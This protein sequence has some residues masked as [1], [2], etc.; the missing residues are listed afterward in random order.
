MRGNLRH[1]LRCRFLRGRHVWY[2]I[3]K[4]GWYECLICGERITLTDM[5]KGKRRTKWKEGECDTR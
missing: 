1:R 3:A 4:A 2:P 5:G